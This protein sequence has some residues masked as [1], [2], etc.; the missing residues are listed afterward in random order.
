[1][2]SLPLLKSFLVFHLVWNV[3]SCAMDDAGA[4]GDGGGEV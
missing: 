2:Q 3:V 4:G 1:M